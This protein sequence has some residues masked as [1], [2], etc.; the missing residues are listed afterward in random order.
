MRLIRPADVSVM[1]TDLLRWDIMMDQV[2]KHRNATFTMKV[3]TFGRVLIE[4][5]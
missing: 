2:W 5:K 3:S 1:R 4:L